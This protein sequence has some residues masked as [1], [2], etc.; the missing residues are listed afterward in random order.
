MQQDLAFV[1]YVIAQLQKAGGNRT[2]TVETRHRFNAV[3][4][5]YH[6]QLVGLIVNN[7]LYLQLGHQVAAELLPGI[8]PLKPT[9]VNV[10]SQFFPV[11][12]AWLADSKQLGRCLNNALLVNQPVSAYA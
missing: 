7:T 2:A 4:I 10:D 3:S 9:G 6:G 5:S 12:L 1:D 8:R 11:P